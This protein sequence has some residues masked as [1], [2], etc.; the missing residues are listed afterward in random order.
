M[1]KR[2]V[3][4]ATI[5]AALSLSAPVTHSQAQAPAAK[6]KAVV[7]QVLDLLKNE[8]LGAEVRRARLRDTIAPNFDFDAMSRSILA[9]AWKK[10]TPEE[11]ARFLALFQKLLEN[12][13]IAAM[14][15][16]AGQSVRF[17]KEKVQGDL[18]TV[19]TFIVRRNSSVETPVHYRMRTRDGRWLAYDVAVEGVSLVN[20]Y[21]SSFRSI[22]RRDGMSGLIQ[23][24][25]KKVN[26][27]G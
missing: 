8:G 9:A 4:L 2:T 17:G 25:D 23:E 1:F 12:T 19:E 21:R 6:V 3:A 10:A 20:N 18:A 11:Q 24:L 22:V 16:Y 5:G 15:D 7:E 13:Y 26:Q 27:A 14:E